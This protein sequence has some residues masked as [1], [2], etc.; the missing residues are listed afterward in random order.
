MRAAE[1]SGAGALGDGDRAGAS[2]SGLE[3]GG[4]SPR[5][6]GGRGHR[7][8]KRRATAVF[9]NDAAMVRA[10][11]EMR[12]P[13]AASDAAAA[14]GSDPG[15]LGTPGGTPTAAFDLAREESAAEKSAQAF[16]E[17][18]MQ[19]LRGVFSACDADK[20]GRLT[21][22]ELCDCL[23]GLGFQPT[24]E[25]LRGFFMEENRRN[26]AEAQAP[27]RRGARRRGGPTVSLASFLAA[28]HL[29]NDAQDCSAEVLKLLGAMDEDGRGTLPAR[30]VKHLAHEVVCPTRLS[31]TEVDELF[32]QC[33]ELAGID[34]NSLAAVDYAALVEELMFA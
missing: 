15:T 21:R 4:A 13:R 17:M 2:A 23:R 14:A 20:D 1:W 26:P 24:D 11:E 5:A 25:L 29:L 30:S 8:A 9:L 18:E 12:T 27:V 33:G 3:G 10:L 16:T 7:Q 34:K 31:R 32:A 22:W 19:M 28:S 6:S